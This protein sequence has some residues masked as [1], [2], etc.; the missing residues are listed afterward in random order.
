M[1]GNGK[2]EKV[3]IERLKANGKFAKFSGK[4]ELNAAMEL[5][6]CRIARVY[7]AVYPLTIGSDQVDGI[8][9]ATKDLD[10]L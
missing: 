9:E 10:T 3:L 5:Q 2:T 1:H 4:R 6:R 8:I 7:T